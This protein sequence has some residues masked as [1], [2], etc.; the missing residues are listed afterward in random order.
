[1]GYAV[2]WTADMG[3]GL[4]ADCYDEI[5]GFHAWRDWPNPFVTFAA[6]VDRGGADRRVWRTIKSAFGAARSTMSM[7]QRPRSVISHG[8]LIECALAA[9]V[10]RRP[11]ARLGRVLLEPRRRTRALRWTESGPPA[12]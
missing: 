8:G 11:D 10:S 5:G 1:M 12:S 2:D 6:F 4:L 7:M 3:A 9:L